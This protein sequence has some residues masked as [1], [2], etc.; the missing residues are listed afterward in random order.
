M[1]TEQLLKRVRTRL[2][3]HAHRKVR[4]LLDGEYT[5]VFHGRSLEFDDLRP[6]VPGD[7][8]KDIDWKAT[9]RLDALMTRRYTASRKQTVVLVVDT[10][11]SMA[12]TAASGES[13]RDL[14]VLAAGTMGYI[15]T[16]HADLVALVAGDSRHT[17]FLRAQ[18]TE[19]HLERLLRDIHSHSTLDAPPSDLTAQLAYVGKAF[20]SGRI[21]VVIADDR[22]LSAT[23]R[24]QLRRLAV[25]HEI[26]W[27]TIADAD[28]MR[29][30]LVSQGMSDVETAVNLPS[31]VRENPALRS[32]FEA[33]VARQATDTQD[34]FDS[35]AISS[36]R[37][38]SEADVVPGLFRLLE[39]HKS[40]RGRSGRGRSGR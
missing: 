40:G 12:A 19:A 33:S 34:L 26:L 23:E 8:V 29:E 14:A 39:L 24:D 37:V 15:A 1:A 25:Q 9:A 6:Y 2:T 16:R 5:S 32:E 18:S 21:L 38:T 31:F 30:A 7:E 35:L 22:A 17:R 27:I 10:G 28:L 13:K 20:S 3:I 4:G 11:R 36:R